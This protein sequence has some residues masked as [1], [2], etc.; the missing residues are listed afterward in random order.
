[1]PGK[2][3]DLYKGMKSTGIILHN[4]RVICKL[5]TTPLH[6]QATPTSQSGSMQINPTKMAVNLH[7]W[8]EGGVKTEDSIEK[9]EGGKMESKA[10]VAAGGKALAAHEG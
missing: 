8:R 6:P 4:K 9:E 7:T 5:T 2:N 1:M 3:L 10:A